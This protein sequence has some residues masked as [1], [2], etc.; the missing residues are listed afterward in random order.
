M[1]KKKAEDWSTPA[2]W[3]PNQSSKEHIQHLGEVLA[4]KVEE[5]KHQTQQ[6]ERQK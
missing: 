2:G 3:L 1:K 4:E 6:S 5:F